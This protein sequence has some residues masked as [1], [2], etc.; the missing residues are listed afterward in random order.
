MVIVGRSKAVA[1]DIG[2]GYVSAAAMVRGGLRTVR[3]PARI[4]VGR[5]PRV[6]GSAGGDVYRIGGD[7]FAVGGGPVEGAGAL[8]VAKGVS[9]DE[10]V[11]LFCRHA[12]EGLRIGAADRLLRLGRW[13]GLGVGKQ[14]GAF[15]GDGVSV[16]KVGVL[17]DAAALAYETARETGKSEGRAILVDCGRDA[18][19]IDEASWNGREAGVERLATLPGLREVERKVVEETGRVA[20][21]DAVGMVESVSEQKVFAK[22]A[23]RD[24][25]LI[26][27]LMVQDYWS[28]IAPDFRGL[29]AKGVDVI[30]AG[31]GAGLI[32]TRLKGDG[33]NPTVLAEPEV[34]AVRAGAYL[35]REA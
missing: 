31:G 28:T 10:A 30:L 9:E 14:F 8:D 32:A 3:F 18:V 11:S 17:D 35:A 34:A 24:T 15:E 16:S 27:D 33:L 12:L 13:S 20:G 25:A 22:G 29:F 21:G 7:V 26:V 6:G 4:V 5:R 23:W 1:V 19:R 2:Y